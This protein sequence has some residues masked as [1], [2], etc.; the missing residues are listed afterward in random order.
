MN[1][2][3]PIPGM[4]NCGNPPLMNHI[5]SPS[6]SSSFFKIHRQVI[7]PQIRKSDNIISPLN[8]INSVSNFQNNVIQT[9]YNYNN[10]INSFGN[11]NKINNNYFVNN[12]FISPRNCIKINNNINQAFNQLNLPINNNYLLNSSSRLNRNNSTYNNFY[13]NNANVNIYQNLI[14]KSK[15]QIFFDKN[16]FNFLKEKTINKNGKTIMNI[17]INIDCDDLN[18]PEKNLDMSNQISNSSSK[19]TFINKENLNISHLDINIDNNK[20]KR[21]FSN[22]VKNTNISNSIDKKINVKNNNKRFS[23]VKDKTKSNSKFSNSV[24]NS[25]NLLSKNM[26]Y[27]E[28]SNNNININNNTGIKLSTRKKLNR[29]PYKDNSNYNFKAY[30]GNN[31]EEM[32]NNGFTKLNKEIKKFKDNPIILD[33]IDKYDDNDNDNDN[34]NIT[35]EEIPNKTLNNNNFKIKDNNKYNIIKLDDDNSIYEYPENNQLDENIENIVNNIENYQSINHNNTF[36]KDLGDKTPKENMKRKM[37]YNPQQLI[38]S[39]SQIK[40]KEK[41]KINIIKYIKK[42]KE[43]DNY[44]PRNKSPKNNMKRAKAKSNNININ[45]IKEIAKN[46]ETNEKTNTIINNAKNKIILSKNKIKSERIQYNR[47]PPQL[48]LNFDISKKDKNNI[49]IKKE[50]LNKSTSNENIVLSDVDNEEN[51]ILKI[52]NFDEIIKI[53]KNKNKNLAI[54]NG[55]IYDLNKENINKKKNNNIHTQENINHIININNIKINRTNENNNQEKKNDFSKTKNYFSDYHVET[56]PGTELH[57]K[58]KINQDIPLAKINVNRING[59]NLFGVLDGHGEFGHK[60]SHFARDFIS[61]EIKKNIEKL[62][63]TNLEEIYTELKKD[64]YALIK[65]SYEKVD[66]EL[67]KQEFNSNFSGTTCV[68]VFQIGIHLITANVGDSRAILIYSEDP[69]DKKLKHSKIFELSLDQKPELPK[70][71]KRIYERGGIVDQMLDGRGKRNGPFRVWAGKENYPGLAMS[72]SI[73]DLKGKKCG[74]ISEPE[75]IEYTLDEKSKY[76]IICSDGVWEFLSNENVMNIANKYYLKNN[77]KELVHTLIKESQL[78]WD[79]E[80]VIRDDITVVA[81]FF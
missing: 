13:N 17:D 66:Q 55:N 20:N 1:N 16:K 65:K 30:K 70:E 7:I 3:T 18:K 2:Q 53:K 15:E 25:N 49:L 74:L 77:I 59:F 23:K 33:D 60:I 29:I 47:S 69:K 9:D 78:W 8:I 6:C 76:M 56:V 42:E 36:E 27:S 4:I 32:I 57:R 44:I 64:N 68:I 39:F 79:K 51:N 73:G 58:I 22:N 28:I 21:R 34:D 12:N 61:K 19:N 52:N 45:L 46:N 71:K 41:D 40:E 80:D 63:L 48:K 26:E 5:K 37:I 62:E 75:I 81:V 10:I 24:K 14:T 35:N 43:E 11:Q 54:K 67:L 31:K 72:R 50:K 38:K